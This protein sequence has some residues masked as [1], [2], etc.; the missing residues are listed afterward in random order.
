MKKNKHFNYTG[1]IRL[2]FELPFAAATAAHRIAGRVIIADRKVCRRGGS[3]E[4][5]RSFFSGVYAQLGHDRLN[6]RQF[7]GQPTDFDAQFAR[8]RSSKGQILRRR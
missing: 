6:L 4:Q 7:S 1:S 5:H 2:E 3:V 8:R